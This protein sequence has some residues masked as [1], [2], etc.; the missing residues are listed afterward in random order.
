[1]NNNKKTS[2]I[3]R[4][5]GWLI[6]AFTAS[7]ACVGL[8]AL[9]AIHQQDFLFALWLMFSAILIDAVDGMLARRIKIKDVIPEVDGALLDM[10]EGSLV[11][12][13]SII[14]C[15]TLRS[16]FDGAFEPIVARP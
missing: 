10:T 1:M 6:H 12:I 3:Q 8:L 2:L 15:S 4:S 11:S 5:L 14:S 13:Q 9:L 16:D 7:G